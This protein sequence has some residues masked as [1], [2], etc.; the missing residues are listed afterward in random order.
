M[1]M[2]CVAGSA[3]TEWANR[4]TSD[5]TWTPCPTNLT[6]CSGGFRL[7]GFTVVIIMTTGLHG[8]GGRLA[9]R[10]PCRNDA[11]RLVCRDSR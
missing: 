8:A 10:T 1:A 9:R 3:H 11:L 7:I 6:N 4:T 2:E 5:G